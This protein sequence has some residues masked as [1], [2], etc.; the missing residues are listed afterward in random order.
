[1]KV[2]QE[3]NDSYYLLIDRG[4]MAKIREILAEN[5]KKYRQKLGITQPELAEWANISTNF[6][7]MI[8]QKRKFPAPEIL[9]RIATALKIETSELF[10]TSVSPQA[11]LKKL[12]KEILTDLD[13]AISESVSK[14]IKELCKNDK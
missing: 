1:M 11:E 6:V 9:E 3:L 14:A 13:R 4:K 7:G 12:H 2:C 10:A 5:M 8:E